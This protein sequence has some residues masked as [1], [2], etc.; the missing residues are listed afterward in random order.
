MVFCVLSCISTRTNA[1][2]DAMAVMCMEPAVDTS[3][4]WSKTTP[5]AEYGSARGFLTTTMDS[6]S[7]S[8]YASLPPRMVIFATDLTPIKPSADARWL[9]GVALALHGH[10][11]L[12]ATR[13]TKKLSGRSSHILSST[14]G[15]VML[16]ATSPSLKRTDPLKLT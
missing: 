14:I 5:K 16:C 6:I 8:A 4:A 15:I 13:R 11:V 1:T 12:I 3:T 10:V 9:H 7:D 2:S